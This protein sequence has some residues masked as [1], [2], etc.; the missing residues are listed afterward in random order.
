ML[1]WFRPKKWESL[2]GD[3]LPA[4]ARVSFIILSSYS[5]NMHK[6]LQFCNNPWGRDLA[7]TRRGT[8]TAGCVLLITRSSSHHLQPS[9]R[10]QNTHAHHIY[11][12][13]QPT[14]IPS[15][16]KPQKRTERLAYRRNVVTKDRW[17]KVRLWQSAVDESDDMSTW[18]Q[19][20]CRF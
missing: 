16:W 2:S 10:Q 12:W 11:N 7:S 14:G 13:L 19:Y 5:F 15:P 1:V 18:A 8:N 6:L 20:A 9:P 4:C 17:R 3:C